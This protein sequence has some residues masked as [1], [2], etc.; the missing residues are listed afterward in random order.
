MFIFST[1]D[2]LID[3]LFDTNQAFSN[4]SLNATFEQIT[5][6]KME[7]WIKV[8][9]LWCNKSGKMNSSI[10][11][12]KHL[13]TFAPATRI[14]GLWKNWKEWLIKE[15]FLRKFIHWFYSCN[16]RFS[17]H[18]FLVYLIYLIHNFNLQQYL[19]LV[20]TRKKHFHWVGVV[21]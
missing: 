18:R 10:L 7:S 12:S 4:I 14:G 6:C 19:Q 17:D 13:P 8:F 15:G 9:L 16:H 5:R 11:C 21:A 1:A 2:K 3:Y 20:A